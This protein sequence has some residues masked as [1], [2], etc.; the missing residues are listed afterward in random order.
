MATGS[1]KEP[2]RVLD[3]GCGNAHLWQHY[4]RLRRPVH[5]TGVDLKNAE[6]SWFRIHHPDLDKLVNTARLPAP[7][8]HTAEV[9][10]CDNKEF[11]KS[12]PGGRF[13]QVHIHMPYRAGDA[14]NLL[15]DVHRVLKPGGYA[16][17]TLDAFLKKPFNIGGKRLPS[18]YLPAGGFFGQ[19]GSNGSAESN[20]QLSNYFRSLG[21]TIRHASLGHSTRRVEPAVNAQD[22][23]SRMNEGN[24]NKLIRSWTKVP[25]FADQVIVLQ[26]LVAPPKRQ[27]TLARLSRAFSWLRLRSRQSSR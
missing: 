21:F 27:T 25:G 20:A 26:K 5:Y 9:I 2:L 6:W 15:G 4:R 19:S 17:I 10:D 14:M 22:R 3:L 23:P 18:G 13:D 24:I 1:A 16:Y 7:A 12:Q 8:G 11:L